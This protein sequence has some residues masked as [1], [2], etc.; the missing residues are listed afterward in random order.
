MATNTNNPRL[1]EANYAGAIFFCCSL[2]ALL[3]DHIREFHI[4]IRH[5]YS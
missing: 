1:S 3:H 4:E 2:I 5:E